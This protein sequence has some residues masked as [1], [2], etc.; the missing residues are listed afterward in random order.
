MALPPEY[1]AYLRA[2]LNWFERL[3]DVF[4]GLD[5]RVDYTNALLTKLI[6]LQ[7]GVPPEVPSWT[8]NL[9]AV[10]HSL[11]TAITNLITALSVIT[12]ISAVENPTGIISQTKLVPIAGIAVQ[13]P[14]VR[15]YPNSEVVI[16]ALR[17]NVGTIYVADSKIDAEGHSSAYSL[18]SGEAIGYKVD[19]LSRLWIDSSI[20]DEG[21][22]WTIERRVT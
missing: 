20:S 14:P 11:N 9:I 2:S 5:E 8:T 4:S 21:V 10:L 19:N 17:K 6:E 13:L 16:K 3:G 1:E 15:V 22:V 7:G 18:V 12:G